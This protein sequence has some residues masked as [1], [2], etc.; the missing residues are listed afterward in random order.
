MRAAPGSAGAPAVFPGPGNI[1]AEDGL[2]AWVRIIEAGRPTIEATT[3]GGATWH[4][5]FGPEAAAPSPVGVTWT[6]PA[7]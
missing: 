4:P 2:R 1:E 5:A 6:S 7:T 3:D